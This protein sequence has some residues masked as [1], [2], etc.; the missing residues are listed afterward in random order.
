MLFKESTMLFKVCDWFSS[1]GGARE[2]QSQANTPQRGCDACSRRTDEGFIVDV[3]DDGQRALI[4]LL[5]RGLDLILRQ[6]ETVLT[7][8]T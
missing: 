5:T 7:L 2:P 6:H 1:D 8:I 4:R 3:R